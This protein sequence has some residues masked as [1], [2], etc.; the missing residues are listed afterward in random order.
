ME[1]TILVADDEVEILE[2]IELYL[3][4][5]GYNIITAQ[6]GLEAL[7]VLRKNK[8]H[9]VILDIM[10]PE[11]DGLKVL[12]K[13]RE[14][15]T[16]PVIILSA[17]GEDYSKILGINLG[18]D[19]YMVKPFNPLELVA[20][21][22]GQLRRNY[23]YQVSRKEATILVNREIKLNV[24]EAEVTLRN[25]HVELTATE[26]KILY[27]LMNRPG[28]IFTKQQIFEA[29]WEESFTGDSSSIMV[30]ISN[31]RNKLEDDA[32]NPTY[33]KTIKGLG[34]KIE[35]DQ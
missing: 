8:I 15:S 27:L 23:D 33:L 7:Q 34:Y 12:M 4:K 5:E 35:K 17:K 25:R 10:M 9:L 32:K 20:R 22:Q 6:N 16:T 3:S 2:V 11:L 26:Y 30:H 24:E 29:I 14:E 31:L 19:D 28:H 1:Y 21:V 18:A 13:L